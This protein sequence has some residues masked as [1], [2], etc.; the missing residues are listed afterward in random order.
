M[1]NNAMNYY[2]VQKQVYKLITDYCSTNTY[3]TLPKTMTDDLSLRNNLN[4]DS[5]NE[6]ELIMKI[7]KTFHILIEDVVAEQIVTIGDIVKIVYD[8]AGFCKE[9]NIDISQSYQHAN[10]AAD[11]I[12]NAP[13]IVPIKKPEQPQEQIHMVRQNNTSIMFRKGGKTLS[14]ND[15]KVSAI[16]ERIKQELENTK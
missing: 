14:L 9:K 12:K 3:C 16:L 4:F 11:L 13:D 5:L 2:D 6:V 15:P 1:Q 10:N 8:K 7:E